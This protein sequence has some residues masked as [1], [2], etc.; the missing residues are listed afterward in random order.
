MS[1]SKRFDHLELVRPRTM[2][3]QVL[4]SDSKRVTVRKALPQS[5]ATATTDVL[6]ANAEKGNDAPQQE[7]RSRCRLSTKS[8]SVAD[9]DAGAAK[10]QV[11][12]AVTAEIPG[13]PI[14][15]RNQKV[16]SWLRDALPPRTNHVGGHRRQRRPTRRDSTWIGEISRSSRYSKASKCCDF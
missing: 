1:P 6:D 7:V 12:F 14:V 13:V 16:V 4:E 3:S 9:T 15:Y 5:S 2:E 11:Y 10:D 8:T